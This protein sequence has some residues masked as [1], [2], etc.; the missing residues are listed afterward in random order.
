M[1][2]IQNL[3]RA[4]GAQVVL[5]DVQLALAPGTIHGLVGANGAGKT[6]LL[7]CLYGLDTGYT[8]QVRET[9]GLSIRQHTGLLPYEPFFYPK[10]TGRE[11]LQF[12]LQARGQSL[13]DFAGWNHILDL[14][15]DQYAQEYSAGMQKKLALLALLVQDL[16]Y[17][18]LDEPF[19]GLDMGT[20]LL[21]KEILLRLRR[22]G[23]GIL[24][25][26]HLLGTLTETCDEITVLAAGTV[27]RHYRTPEFGSLATDLLDTFY[28]DKLTQLARQL[29]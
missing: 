25:T 6:T 23:T 15:L 21:L 14:P 13:V 26:S 28:Q 7:H 3:H 5:R 29:P 2:S 11:Y 17:L 20:N 24:L 9:T 4:F 22:R 16:R 12:C 8:G 1:I 18:I 27:Q 10:L 19:N